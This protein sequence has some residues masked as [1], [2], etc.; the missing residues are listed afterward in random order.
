MDFSSLFIADLERENRVTQQIVAQFLQRRL[1]PHQRTRSSPLLTAREHPT[2]KRQPLNELLHG[3][4]S[5]QGGES[6]NVAY[7]RTSDQGII[8]K[9]PIW[10][11]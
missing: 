4:E 5:L 7:L 3:E 10:N 8:N 9:K 6:E 11:S 2:D 1:F